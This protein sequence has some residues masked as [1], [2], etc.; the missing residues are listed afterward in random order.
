MH[1]NYIRGIQENKIGR[2]GLGLVILLMS[3]ALFAPF[4]TGW[5]PEHSSE[6]TLERP[7]SA[8]WLGTN[9]LGQDIGSRVVSGTRTS[10]VNA[11][12]VGLFTVSLAALGGGGGALLGGFYERLMLRI[13]DILLIIPNILLIILMASYIRPGPVMMIVI[14]SIFN[15]QGCARIIRAQTLSLKERGHILAARAS[16]AG[17]CYILFRHIIPDLGPILASSFITHARRA[18]F[19]EAGLAFLGIANPLLISWGTII[20]RALQYSYLNVWYWIIPPAL[21]LSVTVMAF[22]FLGYALE[23]ILNPRLKA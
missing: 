6:D 4:V 21:G 19:M 8:H 11:F 13:T 20:S 5:N 14:L 23:E 22:S 12:F 7:S 17:N 3:I 1:I 2:I 9:D 10:F 15:W 18:V 16:G